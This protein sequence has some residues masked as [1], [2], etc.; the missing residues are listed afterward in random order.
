MAHLDP[1]VGIHSRVGVELGGKLIAEIIL[2]RAF[3]DRKRLTL[4][5]PVDA[6]DAVLQTD[7]IAGNPHNALDHVIRWIQRKMKY[8]HVIAA[9]LLIGQEPA[10]GARRPV[11]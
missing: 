8:D 9:Y 6:D 4:F 2:I 5:L 7:V 11:N 3:K 1:S 10:P